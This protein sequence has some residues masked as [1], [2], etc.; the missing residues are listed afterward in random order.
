VTEQHDHKP[1]PFRRSP[2]GI[3]LIAFLAIAGFFLWQEHRTHLLG[4]LPYLLLLTC[5][6]LHFFMHRGHGGHGD[7]GNRGST[8]GSQ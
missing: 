6:L 4:I 7:H 1:E 3:V 5:P 8:D 2:A